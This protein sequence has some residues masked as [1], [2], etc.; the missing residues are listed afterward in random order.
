MG[1]FIRWQLYFSPN[2]FFWRR[3]LAPELR[4][5]IRKKVVHLNR[6]TRFFVAQQGLPSEGGGG[7]EQFD[8]LIG[9][10]HLIHCR[11]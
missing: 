7:P 11:V 3:S 10:T 2:Q 6:S 8:R 5:S 1:F 9:G 4:G